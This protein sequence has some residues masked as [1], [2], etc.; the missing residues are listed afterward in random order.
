MTPAEP[1][2]TRAAVVPGL[3]AK[4]AVRELLAICAEDFERHRARLM[5]SDAP[6]GPHGARV[7]LRRLRT[8]LHA[9]RPLLRRARRRAMAQEARRLFRLLGELRDADVLAEA[10]AEGA[11]AEELTEAAAAMRAR[12]RAAL[13]V[14][15]ADGF[16]ARVTALTEGG[17]WWRRS[18]RRRVAR[19]V[20]A[21]AASAL[22]EAWQAARAHGKRVAQMDTDS[23]HGFRKDLKTLR[24]M[25]DFFA[26]LWP[27]RR[28]RRF[29]DRLKR[30]QDALGTLNDIAVTEARLGATGQDAR[31]EQAAAALAAAER[32]WRRLR[33]M[34][35]WW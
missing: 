12:V 32:E 29:L 5:H 10:A 19:P 26:P 13:R 7:A 31:A 28:Q 14:V 6:E 20:E 21:P 15:G 17:R 18:A 4:R 25:T 35:P 2:Q 23:R 8:A 3:P 30:L 24:Y 33:R 22:Q 27:G 9:C 16:S 1:S 34:R 11:E